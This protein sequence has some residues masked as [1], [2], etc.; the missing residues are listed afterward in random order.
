MQCTWTLINQNFNIR[1]LFKIKSTALIQ[2]S[3]MEEQYR[4]QISLL[5]VEDIG[6][7]NPAFVSRNSKLGYSVSN[8]V[9][10]MTQQH[11]SAL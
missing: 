6:C 8:Y 1:M 10:S 5:V 3:D 7:G 2:S 4:E 11:N 9:S